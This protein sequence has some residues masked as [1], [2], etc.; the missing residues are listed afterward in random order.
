MANKEFQRMIVLG[1]WLEK[2]LNPDARVWEYRELLKDA[3]TLFNIDFNLQDELSLKAVPLVCEQPSEVK[4]ILSNPH[5]MGSL[6]DEVFD[7][8]RPKPDLKKREEVEEFI[9]N[10]EISK[11]QK[12]AL[13]VVLRLVLIVDQEVDASA[14]LS[15]LLKTQF[16]FVQYEVLDIFSFK[17]IT[18]EVLKKINQKK[19][20][21]SNTFKTGL[22]SK[23]SF[24]CFSFY[25]I[26]ENSHSIFEAINIT[27][28]G[29]Y[30]TMTFDSPTCEYT[31]LGDGYSLFPWGP[32]VSKI[33][34]DFLFLGGQDYYLFCE[35]CDR[36]AVIR[37]KGRKKFCSDLCRTTH[38]NELK[39]NKIR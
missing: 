3:I 9:S 38:G 34:I 25:E 6:W 7:D 32:V 30:K 27:E 39:M 36:F 18:N 17:W 12:A 20:L 5:I 28:E 26:Y 1:E 4:D 33:L 13:W 19:E 29:A 15:I 11:H 23:D 16:S 35:Q 37:R 22:D 8:N 10:L 24:T 31:S 2:Y 21:W 14:M